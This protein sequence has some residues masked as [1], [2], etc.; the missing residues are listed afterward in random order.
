MALN[1]SDLDTERDCRTSTLAGKSGTCQA[2]AGSPGACSPHPR[3]MRQATMIWRRP[4]TRPRRT[5][6]A[7]AWDASVPRSLFGAACSRGGD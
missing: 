2:R 7:R 4:S 5:G 1:F 6:R 3:S